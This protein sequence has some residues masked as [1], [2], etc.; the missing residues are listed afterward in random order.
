MDAVFP[1]NKV[2]FFRATLKERGISHDDKEPSLSSWEVI[3]EESG[4][5]GK[6]GSFL[7]SHA[8][9]SHDN[10]EPS[11]SSWE[12]SINILDIYN[13]ELTTDARQTTGESFVCLA[14]LPHSSFN[15]IV[16]LSLSGTR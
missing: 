7:S 4:L 1:E 14:S 2:R 9:I 6:Q 12:V 11:L 3:L 10:K 15:T 13:C 5:P 8:G 16:R